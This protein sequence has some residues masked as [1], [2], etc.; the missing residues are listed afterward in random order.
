MK[1]LSSDV[2]PKSV[3]IVMKRAFVSML[4]M[5]AAMGAVDGHCP[6]R[7]LPSTLAATGHTPPPLS[8]DGGFYLTLS[9][10]PEHYEPGALYTVS[11]RVRHNLIPETALRTYR[12]QPHIAGKWECKMQ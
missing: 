12:R 11:L 1:S 7:Q 6:V 3:L 5:A 2:F 10:N 9:G 4:V 8:T